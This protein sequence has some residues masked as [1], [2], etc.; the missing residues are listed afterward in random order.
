MVMSEMVTD[1]ERATYFGYLTG[2]Q[3]LGIGL[4]PVVGGLLVEVGLG[5]RGV[6]LVAGVLCVIAAALVF[7][8]GWIVPDARTTAART[9]AGTGD[10]P[11]TLFLSGPR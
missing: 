1:R 11:G 6:F 2:T 7:V 4:G 9:G 10:E 5:F 8:V 3:Q